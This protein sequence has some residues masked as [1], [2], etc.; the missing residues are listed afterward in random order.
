M[1]DEVSPTHCMRLLI[2]GPLKRTPSPLPSPPQPNHKTAVNTM[3][4]RAIAKNT[5]IVVMTTI[6]I[7]ALSPPRSPEKWT[8]EISFHITTPTP[9]SI[10]ET[11][12]RLN[13]GISTH[14]PASRNVQ[15]PLHNLSL[16]HFITIP[17]DIESSR[18]LATNNAVVTQ[19]GYTARAA[20]PQWKLTFAL[21]QVWIGNCPVLYP[22]SDDA[23]AVVLV[24]PME[25]VPLNRG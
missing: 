3:K 4:G 17:A 23:T 15:N 18:Y 25:V 22:G 24:T 9:H 12:S 1:L 21:Q 8:L 13:S 2:S 10:H 5:S 14:P 16:K 7:R 11:R 20:H 19:Y 6:Y